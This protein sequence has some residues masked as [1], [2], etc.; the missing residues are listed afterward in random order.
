MPLGILAGLTGIAALT[1]SVMVY[2]ATGRVWWRA[3]ATGVR[4]AMTAV[5]CGLATVLVSTLGWSLASGG[6]TAERALLELGRPLAALLTLA[7]AAKL[8]WEAGI[9]RHLR[10]TETTDL[11]R[12][13]LLLARDLRTVTGWRFGTGVV[14]GIGLPLLILAVAAQPEPSTMFC[15]VAAGLGLLVVVA[16]ELLERSLFFTACAAPRMPGGL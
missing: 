15:A 1:C 12:T 3:R 6:E 11:G 4:F 14:G 7:C 16:G 8:V 2:A 9:F 13:A 5:V 10:S